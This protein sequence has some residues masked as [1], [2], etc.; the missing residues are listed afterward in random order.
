MGRVPS[1]VRLIG[2]SNL[3]CEEIAL[4]IIAAILY[5][6]ITRPA[7]STVKPVPI[8][9]T[10]PARPASPRTLDSREG[11]R[12]GG[13]PVVTASLIKKDEAGFVWM[14]VPKNYRSAISSLY[15]ITGLIL[16]L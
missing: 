5:Y 10:V 1:T 13:A 11:R 3:R 6:S 14:T 9:E 15:R 7:W 12:G 4:L 16:G 8:T 2:R